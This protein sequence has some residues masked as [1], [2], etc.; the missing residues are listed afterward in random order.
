MDIKSVEEAVARIQST[1]FKNSNKVSIGMLKSSI[2]GSGLTFRD[3][4]VYTHGDD[5]RFIDWKMMAKTSRP[6]IKT[7][8][9]ERNVEIVVVI[10]ASLSMFVGYKGI[11]KLKVAIEIC[12]L[13]YLLAKETGDTVHTLI[14]ADKI[15]NLPKKMGR[16]GIALLVTQLQRL[17]IINEK[18]DVN[19]DYM[20]A[21]VTNDEQRLK[22]VMR[23]LIKRREI[24]LLSDFVDFLPTKGIATIA[25]KNNVHCFKIVSPLDG[26]E[27]SRYTVYGMETSDK[28]FGRKDLMQVASS[29]EHKNQFLNQALGKKLKTLD[30]KERYL[31]DFIK[32]ML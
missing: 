31:E 21:Q 17:N 28:N 6:Y 5:V 14:V 10:D 1:L 30:V 23:H 25:A 8:E 22:E 16:E 15:Y 7:F 4:Q 2:R 13:L 9:E 32:E 18:G 26:K 27:K 19:I 24:I 3:H 11:S 12:C 29:E 20:P